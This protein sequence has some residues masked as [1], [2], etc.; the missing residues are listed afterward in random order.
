[1]GGISRMAGG[2]RFWAALMSSVRAC[3]LRR[4]IAGGRMGAAGSA[5]RRGWDT[6]IDSSNERQIV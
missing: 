5:K 1:M 3:W 6:T 4:A 2:G